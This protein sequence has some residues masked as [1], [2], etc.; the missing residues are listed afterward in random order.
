MSTGVPPSAHGCITPVDSKRVAL[1]ICL[2]SHVQ[3]LRTGATMPVQEL[4]IGG[5]IFDPIGDCYRLIDDIRTRELSLSDIESRNFD[6]LRPVFLPPDCMGQGTPSRGLWVSPKQVIVS[7]SGRPVCSD[8]YMY[9]CEMHAERW[10]AGGAVSRGDFPKYSVFRYF[11]VLFS[12][13]TVMRVNGVLLRGVTV[14][15][16]TNPVH[17]GLHG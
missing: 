15:E 14:S 1:M 13:P 12:E 17:S 16:C 2:N 11:A 3:V 4:E 5:L 6:H 10:I 9:S 8:Q 7:L